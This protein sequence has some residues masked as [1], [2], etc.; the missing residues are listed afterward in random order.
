MIFANQKTCGDE[1]LK[2]MFGYEDSTEE[3]TS[4]N[5]VVLLLAQMQMGKSG[6]YWYVIFEALRNRKVDQVLIISGNRE[7]DLRTQVQQDKKAYTNQYGKEF[8]KQITILWGSDLYSKRRSI[9][10]VPNNTLIVWDEAHFAQSKSNGPYKFFKHNGLEGMLNGTMNLKDITDRNIY[11]LNVSATPFSELY[12]NAL[13]PCPYHEVV[14]L[15]PDSSYFGVDF[16]INDRRL[17][18]SFEVDEYHVSELETLLTRYNT[19]DNPRYMLIRVTNTTKATRLVENICKRLDIVSHRM[20]SKV[21]TI[22][23]DDLSQKPRKPTVVVLSGMLRMGKV[24]PKEHLAMVFEAK[25]PK[26]TRHID[27]G[28]QGLLGRVCGHTQNPSGFDI[29][30]Y[31]EPNLYNYVVYYVQNYEEEHG[32]LIKPAMNLKTSLLTNIKT[33]TNVT[34]LTLTN[35]EAPQRNSIMKQI[36]EQFP[37]LMDRTFVMKDLNKI[38]NGKFYTQI[39]KN[40][41]TSIMKPNTCYVCKLFGQDEN[42]V[43]LLVDNGIE[44]QPESK[45]NRCNDM[46]VILDQCVYKPQTKFIH[47]EET[48]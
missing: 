37:E 45:N 4:L 20:N 17:C 22:S 6:T 24:V 32:P 46:N 11:L 30:V 16:Y 44:E 31:I 18:Q 43:W 26:N 13:Q 27:T 36:N 14:R 33:D 47:L 19:K 34:C 12:A 8:N 42:K 35:P 23:I 15:V 3:S 39:E 7:K 1:I 29:D 38:S 41:F 9:T 25:T 5:P 2:T 48:K 21:R 40:T 10:V 28:L